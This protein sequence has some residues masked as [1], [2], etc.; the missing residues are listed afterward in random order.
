MRAC[1]LRTNEELL[2]SGIDVTYS[3]ATTVVVMAFENTLYCA[4]IGDS[5]AVFK[6]NLKIYRLLEDLI[7]NYQLLN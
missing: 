3:G 6:L 5:R 1:F 4:N 7:I 2:N